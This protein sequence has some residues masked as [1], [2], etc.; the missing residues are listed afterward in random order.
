MIAEKI[1][2]DTDEN[3]NIKKLPTLPPNKHIELI[4]LIEESKKDEKKVI[5]EPSQILS[6]KMTIKDDIFTSENEWT[7]ET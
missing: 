2:V 5:R 1:F 7:L 6:G 4:I 3:G